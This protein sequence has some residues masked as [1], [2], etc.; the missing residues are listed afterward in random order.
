[1]LLVYGVVN[2]LGGAMGYVARGS[3]ES[4]IAG[5]VFGVLLVL[6][7]LFA[8]KAPALCY[9]GAGLLALLL[10]L[11]W[12]NRVNV[13]I[14]AGD[15]PAMPAGNLALAALVLVLLAVAHF[16]GAKSSRAAT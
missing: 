5:A 4:L 16:A 13:V 3:I 11:F 6:C 1:M 15:S 2:I 12:G 8:Q 7:A 10:V 9:R 14:Q